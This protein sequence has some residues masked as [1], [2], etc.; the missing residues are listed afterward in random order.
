[1]LTDLPQLAGYYGYRAAD[2]ELWDRFVPPGLVARIVARVA[3]EDWV[4]V[5]GG[6]AS[7]GGGYLCDVWMGVH[8]HSVYSEP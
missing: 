3:R 1:M 5:G 6:G 4:V 8:V 2:V 7:R